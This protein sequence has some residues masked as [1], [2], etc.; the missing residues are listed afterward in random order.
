MAECFCG[1]GR[2]VSF[3]KRMANKAGRQV[4]SGLAVLEGKIAPRFEPARERGERD[5]FMDRVDAQLGAGHEFRE[6][7]RAMVHGDAPTTG[8]PGFSE[9][10]RDVDGMAAF[11]RLS[12]ER[13]QR[14]I[15]RG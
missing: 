11:F 14:I 2:K 10:F 4:E 13:Q 9:W 8:I 1:C 3:G 5:A 15:D 12:P 7:F 6:Q